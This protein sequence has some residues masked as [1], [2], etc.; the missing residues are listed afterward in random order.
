[1]GLLCFTYISAHNWKGQEQLNLH[2]IDSALS[3]LQ[4]EI[5]EK[6]SQSGFF[7]FFLGD[8]EKVVKN[9]LKKDK[10]VEFTLN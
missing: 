2:V 10:L 6:L 3:H 7:F 9:F 5:S 8:I 4:L 1:M